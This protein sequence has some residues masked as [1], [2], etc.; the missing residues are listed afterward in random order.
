MD[1]RRETSPARIDTK[2]RLS[3]F[4]FDISIDPPTVPAVYAKRD[5]DTANDDDDLSKRLLQIG[6]HAKQADLHS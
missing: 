5:Q 4:G 6:L 2:C 3:Y 1:K